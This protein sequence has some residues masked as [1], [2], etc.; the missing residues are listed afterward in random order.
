MQAED[1]SNGHTANG[2]R[3]S[4]NSG[5][6]IDSHDAQDQPGNVEESTH[7]G[8]MDAAAFLRVSEGLRAAFA[9]VTAA[10]LTPAEM[11]RWQHRLIA[12]TNV[13]KRDLPG[14]LEQ[15]ER[16]QSAWDARRK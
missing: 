13:A 6:S 11:T 16:F 2:G 12:I 10:K 15:L 4:R 3:D 9:D 8:Q 1:E 7:A 14:A 5:D